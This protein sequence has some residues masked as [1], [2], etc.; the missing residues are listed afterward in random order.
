MTEAKNLIFHMFELV[1]SWPISVTILNVQVSL[2]VSKHT[3][4]LTFFFLPFLSQTVVLWWL[5]STSTL[6]ERHSAFCEGLKWCSRAHW[7]SQSGITWAASTPSWWSCQAD[8]ITMTAAAGE[9]HGSRGGICGYF[10]ATACKAGN[11]STSQDADLLPNA[12][13]WLLLT[14]TDNPSTHKGIISV[15]PC[16]KGFSYN[17]AASHHCCSSSKDPCHAS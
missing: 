17:E 1:F 13:A 11:M 16:P 9:L 14:P 10:R 15:I 4:L 7:P 5:G 3:A 6:R 8:S 2:P 12:C